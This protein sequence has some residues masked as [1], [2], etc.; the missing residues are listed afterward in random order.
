MARNVDDAVTPPPTGLVRN[1]GPDGWTSDQLR[2]FLD[3]VADS[4]YLPA[5]VFLAATGCRRGECL[6]LDWGDLDIDTAWG[7]RTSR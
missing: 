4:G 7:P 1:G 2:S 6:G 5:W 3:F